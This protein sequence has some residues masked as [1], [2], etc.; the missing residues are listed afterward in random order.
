[1]NTITQKAMGLLERGLVKTAAVL[2]VRV[3]EPATLIEIDLHVPGCDMGRW[4]QT[5]HIKC[6]VAPFV[7][8]DYTPFGWDAGTHTCTLLIDAAHDGPGSCWAKSLEEGDTMAYLGVSSAH[9]EPAPGRRMVLLG[10]ETSISHFLALRQLA[11]V[12]AVIDGAIIISD[13]NHRYAFAHYFPDT[14]L[15]V[16]PGSAKGD[17]STL[18]DWIANFPDDDPSGTVFYLAGNIPGIVGLRKLL[19]RKGYGSSQVKAQGFWE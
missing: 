13:A 2:A 1:M 15:K 8:R 19:R 10:D 18:K 6:R 12:D 7:Y 4:R 9:H 11:G 5:Q 17:Y 14:G 3:W 16:L